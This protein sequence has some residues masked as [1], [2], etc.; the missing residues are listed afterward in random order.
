MVTNTG[1]TMKILN[2]QPI[3]W[4]IYLP[5]H[6]ALVIGII[7]VIGGYCSPLWLLTPFIGYLIMGYFGGAIFVHRYWCHDSFKTNTTL[8]RIGAYLGA[9]SGFGSPLAVCAIHMFMH[10]PY[11]DTE[12]DPHTPAFNGKLF[13]WLTWKNQP[14]EIYN[15]AFNRLLK[16]K[17]AL[18]RDKFI[19]FLHR[20][21]E[22]IWWGTLLVLLLLDW[23]VA[24]F[25]FAGGGVY[26]FHIEGFVNSF[27]HSKDSDGYTIK[28]TG[29]HS[30]N[31][32]SKIM[33]YLSLGNTLHHNHHVFPAN[34]SYKLKD[35]EF[36]LAHYIVPLIMTN[37]R[38]ER[39]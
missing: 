27:C 22:L 28:D 2:I 3:Y 30:I 39:K 21:Y 35:E 38:A 18:L 7:L 15:V 5:Q 16:S 11:S 13:S 6:L 10:H 23:R 1:I 37:E 17:K 9:M 12:K 29:D 33:M 25:V 26:S 4:K 20:H 34:Y 8:A 32:N 31:H 24:L 36:D 14:A 19:R